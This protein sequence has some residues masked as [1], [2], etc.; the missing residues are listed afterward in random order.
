MS[1]FERTAHH[2]P[3]SYLSSTFTYILDFAYG[4][5]GGE[6]NPA[7][8]KTDFLSFQHPCEFTKLMISVCMCVK[9]I[10][11]VKDSRSGGKRLSQNMLVRVSGWTQENSWKNGKSQTSAASPL[12]RKIKDNRQEA[13]GVL[14]VMF[15]CNE[16]SVA[17]IKQENKT[18]E[19]DQFP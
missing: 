10:T 19:H 15:I 18:P 2:A 1:S 11:V 16:I 12:V 7:P 17:V 3:A 14:D 5:K 13:L 8:L 4:Y 6:Q 9:S